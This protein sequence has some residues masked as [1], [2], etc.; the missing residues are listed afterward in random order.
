[1]DTRR[2]PYT[3]LGVSR[4]EDA[5]EIRHAFQTVATRLRPE[6]AG[7][8]S[9]SWFEDALE[10]FRV[11][12]DP[13]ARAAYDAAHE[14]PLE[15]EDDDEWFIPPAGAGAL[16]TLSLME[17]F[18]AP[19][20]E[21]EQTQDRLRRNFT[22]L[23][24]PKAE[25]LQPLELEVVLPAEEARTGGVLTLRVPTFKTCPVCL[26]SGS[27]NLFPCFACHHE[28]VIEQLE[29]V[30]LVLSPGIASGTTL[31]L[32][33]QGLGIDNLLLRVRVRVE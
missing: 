8:P 26:G 10:A 4:E 2:D 22:G 27:E 33:L 1:M 13:M 31:S 23:H 20:M 5:Q 6:R 29:P 3:V 9:E 17:D 19:S 18:T 7:M 32:P 11:L 12:S 25:T 15:D 14:T 21:R 16:G 28:G 24:V 30:R